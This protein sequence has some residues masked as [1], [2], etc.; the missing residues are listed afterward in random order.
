MGKMS[1]LVVSVASNCKSYLMGLNSGKHP[2]LPQW[3]DRL[4]GRKQLWNLLKLHLET[5][6]DTLPLLG[7]RAHYSTTELS[8]ELKHRQIEYLY[9]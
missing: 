5:S 6:S 4:Q 7:E 2:R 1:W 3:E 8:P 9:P